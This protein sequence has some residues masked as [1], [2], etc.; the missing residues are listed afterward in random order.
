MISLVERYEELKKS[1]KLKKQIE[2]Q[3]KKN[4]VKDRKKLTIFERS[5]N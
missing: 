2:K 4:A 1:G 3:R 5:S